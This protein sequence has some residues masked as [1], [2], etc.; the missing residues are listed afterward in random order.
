RNR[1]TL[2]SFNLKRL[3]PARTRKS[4]PA[5]PLLPPPRIGI[6]IGRLPISEM[7]VNPFKY[8]SCL[9]YFGYLMILI[10]VA[11]IGLSYYA[12]VVLTWGPQLLSGHLNGLAAFFILALFHILLILLAWSY[13]MVVI[14]DPGSVPENWRPMLGEHLEEGT[15]NAH[16]NLVAPESSTPVIS[17]PDETE[18]RSAVRYCTRCQ[19]VK[20]P[21]CH[22]CS[23]CQKCILKMDHHCV[24]VVNCVGA[25]NYKFFLLFLFYTFLE[26]VLD[27]LVLL[28]QVIK[29]FKEAV[30]SSGS[31]SSIAITFLAFVLNLAFSL[32]LLCFV[33]MHISLLLSNTTT[34]EVY[35]KRKMVRWKYDLG[36]KRNFIQVF[37]TKKALWFFPMYSKDDVDNP[38][39]QGL[40]FPLREDMFGSSVIC[41]LFPLVFGFCFSY[42]DSFLGTPYLDCCNEKALSKCASGSYSTR[43]D[44]F[45]PG[46]ATASAMDETQMGVNHTSGR[47][48]K[49]PSVVQQRSETMEENHMNTGVVKRMRPAGTIHN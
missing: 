5:T 25:R 12:V 14:Q 46:K 43:E 31:A 20:P 7:D 47:D 15:S 28:P 23:V 42:D 2:A 34:I 21:R 36:R 1:K 33:V 38:T 24:W 10:V 22:H 9:K 45:K 37:G 49:T 35:E 26:T 16:P 13:V 4:P 17:V 39:F 44:K 8:C 40:N 11:I 6:G 29:S 48:C 19:N 3:F 41:S 32:S 30:D 18:T 27:A